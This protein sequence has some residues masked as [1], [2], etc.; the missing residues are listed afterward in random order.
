MRHPLCPAGFLTFVLLL[1]TSSPLYAQHFDDCLANVN[2]ATVVVPDS[3]IAVIGEQQ[4]LESGDEIA[5]F[6]NDGNC[7]GAATWNGT[8]LSIAVAGNDGQTST[9][10]E[11]DETLKYRIWDASAN[12]E[13]FVDG[14][15]ISYEPCESENFPCRDDGAYYNDVFYKVDE[16]ST[17]DPL[18]VELISFEAQLDGKQAVLSWK[19]ASE[20][21]NA[22][23]EVQHQRA[24][25]ETWHQ[26]GF[27]EGQGTTNKEQAYSYQTKDLGPGTHQFRLKQVDLDGAFE[28]SPTVELTLALNDGPQ[29]SAPYPNPFSGR[30]QLSL[31]LASEQHVQIAVYNTLGQQVLMLHRG[32]LK[33]NTQHTFTLDGQRLPSGLYL[34]QARGQDFSMTRRAVLTK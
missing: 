5:L 20:T 17:G 33:A 25:T 30:A 14:A 4:S 15:S 22:G 2:N 26:L 19:T 1:L 9:G 10:Y 29:L 31:T 34:I 13:Y 8:T 6:T 16:L 11:I 24:E 7:A 12:T 28:Y 32:P 21:N 18:P 23:F 3:V 27:V